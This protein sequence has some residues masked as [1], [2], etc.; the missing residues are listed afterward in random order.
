MPIC[1]KGHII[2]SFLEQ[3]SCQKQLQP[4]TAASFKETMAIEGWRNI[5]ER[6]VDA[7]DKW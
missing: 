7:L 1:L 2:V 5:D 3:F 6:I 4:S